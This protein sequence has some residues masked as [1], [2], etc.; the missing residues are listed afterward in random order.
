MKTGV[1]L[2]VV[3]G[4]SSDGDVLDATVALSRIYDSH[5]EVLHPRLDPYHVLAG[6][7]DGINGLGTSDII[8]GIRQDIERRCRLA[9]A[10]F[11][12][13]IDRHGIRLEPDIGK[14]ITGQSSGPTTS[15][16][17][18]EGTYEGA[19]TQYGRL[20]DLIVV[21][22]PDANGNRSQ[23][24]IVESALFDTGRPVMC[25]PRGFK[26]FDTKRAAIMWNGSL[27]AARAVG[28]AMPLL[29]ACGNAVVV[30]AG[31]SDGPDATELVERLVL[32]GIEART[33]RI[34]TPLESIPSALLAVLEEV[35]YG[36]IVM[37]GYGHS[38][39]REM[40]L[41]GV[42]RQML[43]EAKVPVLLAH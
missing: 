40:L 5:I 7:I 25:I 3:T 31:P 12:S 6:L 26:D 2:A 35:K 9:Q 34:S 4:A 11:A 17:Q 13:W 41:G 36:L 15:W 23:E 1:I 10:S 22:L 33:R 28:D 30:T 8:V 24:A 27:Q 20:A 19:M 16:R 43:A 29:S 38:R 32:R 21:S 39:L 42:T 37:G 14:N 18:F